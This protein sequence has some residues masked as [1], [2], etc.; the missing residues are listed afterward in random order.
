MAYTL[1]I[2]LAAP[3]WGVLW[4][5]LAGLIAALLLLGLS[6]NLRFFRAPGKLIRI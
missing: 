2:W 4:S 1:T 6:V 5:T 3:A